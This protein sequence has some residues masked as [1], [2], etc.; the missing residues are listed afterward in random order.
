MGT[1]AEHVE[2]V[3]KIHNFLNERA[4]GEVLKWEK[5]ITYVFP[6]RGG[7]RTH[8]ARFNGRPGEMS[9]KARFWMLASWLLPSSTEPPFDRHVPS[10][11]S[12]RSSL[13]IIDYYSAPPTTD[14][15][16]GFA[17]RKGGGTQQAMS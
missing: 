13:L 14:G 1:P 8:L 15:A 5:R 10:A 6:T 12:N 3:V 7:R 4:W 17:L 16:S 2:T 11:R 9:P